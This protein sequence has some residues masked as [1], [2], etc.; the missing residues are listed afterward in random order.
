MILHRRTLLVSASLQAQDV[1]RVI[2][3]HRQRMTA[4]AIAE[5]HAALEVHLPQQIGS[6]LLEAMPWIWRRILGGPDPAVPAQDLMHGGRCRHG[7]ASPLQTM[8]NLARTPSRM[9]VT[10][11]QHLPFDRGLAPP[12]HDMRAARTIRQFPIA[13]FP[14]CQPLITNL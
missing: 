4:R 11:G 3:N 9:L 12:G 8:R 14:A 10:N 5:R 6:L 1:T 13:I 2:V 7:Q